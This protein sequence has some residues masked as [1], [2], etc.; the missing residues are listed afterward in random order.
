METDLDHLALVK[1]IVDY[2]I[3]FKTL[4]W[5][6]FYSNTIRKKFIKSKIKLMQFIAMLNMG[7]LMVDMIFM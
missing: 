4:H 2:T 5:N 6:H 1:Y 7:Q 3:M